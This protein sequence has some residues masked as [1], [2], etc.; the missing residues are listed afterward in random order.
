MSNLLSHGHSERTGGS[1]VRTAAR[2]T[3]QSSRF[4]QNLLSVERGP[5]QWNKRIA[6]LLPWYMKGKDPFTLAHPGIDS[7][8]VEHLTC[9]G[10]ALPL[11]SG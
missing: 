10:H 9:T 1:F 11:G 3:C 2:G 4:E 8:K 5:A 6:V 7:D